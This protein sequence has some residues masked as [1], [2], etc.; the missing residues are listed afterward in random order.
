MKYETTA[1]GF[2]GHVKKGSIVTL[3]EE[4]DGDVKFVVA[5]DGKTDF[6]L[7]NE[8]KGVR[9]DKCST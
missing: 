4:F 6:V 7:G 8:L 5:D 1:N 2:V 9:D 3:Q